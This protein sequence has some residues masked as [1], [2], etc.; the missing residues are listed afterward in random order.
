MQKP[1]L[2]YFYCNKLYYTYRRQYSEWEHNGTKYHGWDE[3]ALA[4]GFEPA[5][6]RREHFNFDEH[7]CRG[8][9]ILGLIFIKLYTYQTEVRE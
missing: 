6:F 1:K 8:Y 7:T 3:W 5:L 4:V 9:T 2:F